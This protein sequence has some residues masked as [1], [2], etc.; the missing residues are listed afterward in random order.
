[1]LTW[2]LLHYS[3]FW[4]WLEFYRFRISF[5]QNP[6]ESN[7]SEARV[8]DGF[9]GSEYS[10][11]ESKTSLEPT[12]QDPRQV[13]PQP[14][15]Q[16]GKEPETPESNDPAPDD[17]REGTP[18]QS[19]DLFSLFSSQ[20]FGD[21][22]DLSKESPISS[23]V[24]TTEPAPGGETLT[25]VASG[26]SSTQEAEPSTSAEDSN[27]SSRGNKFWDKARQRVS[28]RRR[29]RLEHN[30]VLSTEGGKIA[31]CKSCLQSVT[32]HSSCN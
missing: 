18:Q 8:N 9:S 4:I 19:E 1:M 27:A 6:D 32:N 29:S 21:E 10:L 7:V 14:S 2:P 26:S 31:I 11:F 12:K 5:Q 15:S 24:P 22:D 3:R 20:L 17:T 25:T 28:Q 23:P 13:E 16:E 30:R